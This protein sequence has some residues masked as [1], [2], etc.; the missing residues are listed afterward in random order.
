MFCLLKEHGTTPL[1]RRL[2]K[3]VQS[4]ILLLRPEEIYQV[5]V[6][7]KTLSKANVSNT[8][9]NVLFSNLNKNITYVSVAELTHLLTVTSVREQQQLNIA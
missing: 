7:M 9:Q 2:G 6:A 4:D 1:I 5:F 3:V 8:F